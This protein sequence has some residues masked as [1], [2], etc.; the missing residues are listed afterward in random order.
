[1]SQYG[2]GQT[3]TGK[4]FVAPSTETF[5]HDADGNLTSDGRWTYSW[6]GENRLVQMIRDSDS[7]TGARQK[8]VFEYDH[9]GRRVR[10]QFHTYNNGWQ[11]QTDTVFLYDGW[12]LVAELNA[13][14]SNAR[15]RT[16][17]WGTDLSG[18]MQG[19]GGV[20]GL[21]KLTYYGTSTTNAFVAY[22]GNGN[23]VALIDAANGNTCARYEYGP[24]AEPTRSSGPLSKLNPIRFSTKY[25]D[26]E[27]GFLYYG[28]RY[29]NPST[30][31]W[32]NRDPVEQSNASPYSLAANDTTGRWD[33]LGMFAVRYINT[34]PWW[35][36]TKELFWTGLSFQFDQ[37]DHRSLGK[38]ITLVVHHTASIEVAP[39]STR[40]PPKMATSD[41]WFFTDLNLDSSGQVQ[42]RRPGYAGSNGE[43][44]FELGWTGFSTTSEAYAAM[45]GLAGPSTAGYYY[46]QVEYAV[47]PYGPIG[48]VQ[49]AAG[50]AADW[51]HRE[52]S[53]RNPHPGWQELPGPPINNN[54]FYQGALT[55]WFTWDNCCGHE[56][57]SFLDLALPPVGRNGP[58]INPGHN[59]EGI[60][61]GVQLLVTP[62]HE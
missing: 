37:S 56:R 40:K 60:E 11:E 3:E 45:G 16:Y 18:S 30:G 10:K 23:V 21:L 19:A 57:W 47:A 2:G 52:S 28:Y 59:F 6:D 36:P 5:A 49:P 15:V 61:G 17:V 31:R 26:N 8:M 50:P 22:D 24:F 27:S 35:S 20:G 44:G 4:V 62:C 13:N 51:L 33:Y 43:W 48:L 46:T 54:A 55:I 29:Y 25:T 14:S 53:V 42:N 1:V 12:N 39:C 34:S 41:R 58:D 32:L 9:Q 7:P 38:K